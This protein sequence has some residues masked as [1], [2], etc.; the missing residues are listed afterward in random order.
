MQS[1]LAL[2]LVACL[3]I[4][5]AA[6]RGLP[7]LSALASSIPFVDPCP[8]TCD[9]LGSDPFNWTHIHHVDKLGLCSQPL[10]FDLNVQN[11]VNDTSTR[12]TIRA[13][14]DAGLLSFLYLL[15]FLAS[16]FLVSDLLAVLASQIP[17]LGRSLG[18]LL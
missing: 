14:R 7:P 11:P 6:A 8:P 10:L 17:W 16:Y 2:A 3:D 15:A 5:L 12:V 4:S 9:S 13:V 1:H 18:L